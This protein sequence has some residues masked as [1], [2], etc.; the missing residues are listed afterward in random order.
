MGHTVSEYILHFQI[1]NCR[2]I[3]K[4]DSDHFFLVCLF[5]KLSEDKIN[6]M[7]FDRDCHNVFV[8]FL[9]PGQSP[10]SSTLS[11]RVTRVRSESRG[12]EEAASVSTNSA[13]PLPA[14]ALPPAEKASQPV[15]K[16]KKKRPRKVGI[17]GAF[18]FELV[19]NFFRR[20]Q[21]V[22]F[23]AKRRTHIFHYFGQE[24]SHRF[25]YFILIRRAFFR[26]NA[27]SFQ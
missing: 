20:F 21:W 23:S 10:S 19:T 5:M 1:D 22:I 18:A 26:E 11:R 17:W 14:T 4:A 16:T 27:Y 25:P 2:S 12:R 3:L 6:N 15:K 24:F 7:R 8:L 9:F 13:A